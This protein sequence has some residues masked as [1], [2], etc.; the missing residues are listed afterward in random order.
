MLAPVD[1][2]AQLPEGLSPEDAAPLLCAGVTTFNSLRHSGAGPG[3]LVAVLGVGALGHLGIQ[4]ANKFGY[5]VAAVSGGPENEA[6]ARK[7]EA[8][9][10]IDSVASNAAGELQKSGGERV[11]LATAPSGKAMSALF[12]GLGVDGKLVVLG[13]SAEP[14]TATP[15]QLIRGRRGLQGWPSGTSTDSKDTLNF[16]AQAGVR[17]MIEKYPLERAAEAYERMMSGKAEYRAVLTM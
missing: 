6:L 5:Q 16:A 15:V 8:H 12:D 9:H 14:I 11:I 17:P 3:D 4:F 13:A 2:L 10:Y 1:A 7:L